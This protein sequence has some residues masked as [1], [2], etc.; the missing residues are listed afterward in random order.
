[1]CLC[2]FVCVCACVCCI[3]QHLLVQEMEA[4]PGTEP[5]AHKHTHASANNAYKLNYIL[6]SRPAVVVHPCA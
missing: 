6:I 2:V 1:M 4:L 5:M 3:P